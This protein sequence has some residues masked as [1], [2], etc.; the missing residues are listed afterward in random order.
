MGELRAAK[1]AEIA[2]A[3]KL[4]EQ[5][6][7]QKRFKVR[8]D[9][10]TALTETLKIL[11]AD[12]ARDLYENTMSFMQVNEASARA[13]AQDRAKER[14]MQRL[15]AVA[16]KNGNWMLASLAVRVRLDAFTKVK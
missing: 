9:E 15:A 10:I 7:Q 14:S 5:K 13:A 1:L 11:T 2:E 3:T 12:D 6:E 8:S 16:K 4:K